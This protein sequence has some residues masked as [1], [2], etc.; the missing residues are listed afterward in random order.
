MMLG[1]SDLFED[2]ASILG[3]GDR[4]TM[5][6]ARELGLRLHNHLTL[7]TSALSQAE[8]SA[9]LPASLRGFIEIAQQ[10]A[11]LAAKDIGQLLRA[12]DVET[13]HAPIGPART[14]PTMH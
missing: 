5:V 8:S 6:A 9:E 11:A 1:T 4:Q 10:G 12:A 13:K 14:S 7:I 2:G 3:E